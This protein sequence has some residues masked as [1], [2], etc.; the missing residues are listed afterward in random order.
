MKKINYYEYHDMT[1]KLF[2]GV[3]LTDEHMNTATKQIAKY[4]GSGGAQPIADALGIC[5]MERVRGGRV[6]WR[7]LVHKMG[8]EELTINEICNIGLFLPH[9]PFAESAAFQRL[10]RERGIKSQMV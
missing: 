5:V 9:G 4:L 2:F 7:R 3:T 1:E 8:A 10:P 6:V